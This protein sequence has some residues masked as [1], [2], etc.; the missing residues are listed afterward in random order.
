MKW[1]WEMKT[2]L[3]YIEDN[4]YCVELMQL[5]LRRNPEYLLIVATDAM[6]G[7]EQAIYHEPALILMD[8]NLPD[9]T[10]WELTDKLRHHVLTRSIPIIAVTSL[11]LRQSYEASRQAGIDLHISKSIHRQQLLHHIENLL[12]TTKAS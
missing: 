10:G 3:L 1:A 4:P 8:I 7:W 6:T 5:Y 11:T 9:M 2:K 12:I